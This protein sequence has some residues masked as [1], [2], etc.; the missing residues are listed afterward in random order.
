MAVYMSYLQSIVLLDA[1]TNLTAHMQKLWL[2][3]HAYQRVELERS[4]TQGPDAVR[5]VTMDNPDQRIS[6]DCGTFCDTTFG[7]FGGL[8]DCVGKLCVFVPV[9]WRL[10]PSKAFGMEMDC[11]GWLLWCTL[12]MLSCAQWVSIQSASSLS[13]LT[14]CSK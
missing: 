13:Q 4:G 8:I 14:S 9:L 7:V 6:E 5:D 11:P 1:R 3:G 2:R 10:S 12:S